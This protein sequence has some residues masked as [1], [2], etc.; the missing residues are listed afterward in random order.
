[1]REHEFTEATADEARHRT[2]VNEATL[3]IGLPPSTR[4]SLELGMRRFVN[5]PTLAL[6]W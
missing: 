1:M 2:D 6:P 3:E 5:R 4:I